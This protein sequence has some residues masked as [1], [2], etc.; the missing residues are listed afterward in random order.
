[1]QHF[2]TERLA[3]VTADSVMGCFENGIAICPA[4]Y[5]Y[6]WHVF[7]SCADFPENIQTGTIWQ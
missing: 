5:H 2:H 1:M 6:D 7:V 3:D 4:R